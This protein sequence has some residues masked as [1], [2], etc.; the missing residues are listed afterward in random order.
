MTFCKT[1]EPQR[2]E[3]KIARCNRVL[4][5]NVTTCR[6]SFDFVL[7]IEQSRVFL[8]S[9]T[10]LDGKRHVTENQIQIFFVTTK[11][12]NLFIFVQGLGTAVFKKTFCFNFSFE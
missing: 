5:Q 4:L 10:F 1:A 8:L 6:K 7:R 9:G 3:C 12:M 2:E 11:G